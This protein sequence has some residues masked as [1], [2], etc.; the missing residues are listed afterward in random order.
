MLSEDQI[1]ENEVRRIARQL[2]PIA[3]YDGASI[4]EN[5]ERDGIF[6][7]E[8]CIHL[9]E[10]TTSRKKNKAY[11]DSK[12]LITLATRYKTKK[13]KAI[14]CWFITKDE[15]TADQRSEINKHKGQVIALSFTQFQSKLIDV[16]TYLSLRDKYYFGSVR[17]PKDGG[18]TPPIDYIPLDLVET[19]ENR[20][21]SIEEIR[22]YLKEGSK[23]F[24]VGDYGS[25]KSMT[26]RKIYQEFKKM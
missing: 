20:L 16:N 25:G 3:Q 22:N 17:D 2:W 8:E 10:A 7:T 24:I 18:I 4:V 23:F 14:K 13:W 11:D 26:L 21:W 5:R 15:P 12:K 6:E 19:A 9:I 1:F